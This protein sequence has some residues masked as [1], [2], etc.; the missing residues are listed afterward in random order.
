MKQK[1]LRTQPQ[2]NSQTAD[3]RDLS[4]MNFLGPALMIQ[5]ND[6]PVS[7]AEFQNRDA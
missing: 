4:M 3:P 5:T 7:P 6:K 2:K 1:A